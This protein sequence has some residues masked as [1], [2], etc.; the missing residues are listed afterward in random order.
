MSAR[1]KSWTFASILRAAKVR[2]DW[3]QT[4][5][6]ATLIRC[7]RDLCPLGVVFTPRRN[8]SPD[9]FAIPQLR[10]LRERLAAVRVAY[11][12]DSDASPDRGALLKSLGIV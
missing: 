3:S 5:G 7:D 2:G 11:A 8:V 4:W 10:T 9:P 12:A 1:R 6:R